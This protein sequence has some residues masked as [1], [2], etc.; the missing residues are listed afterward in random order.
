M[1]A[2][3]RSL[4]AL[5]GLV[6]TAGTPWAQAAQ[7]LLRSYQRNFVLGG[8]EVKLQIVQDAGK[9]GDRDLGPLYLQAVDFVLANHPLLE[10]EPRCRVLAVSALDLIRA[11]GFGAARS[12]AWDLFETDG[13]SEVRAA[14]LRCLGVI[15]KGD[16]EIVQ[17][18]NLWLQFQNAALQTG[19]APDEAVTA[20]AVQALAAL[21]EPSSFAVLF[22]TMNLGYG[23]EITGLAR[24]ALQSIPGDY[25][26]LFL[27]VMQNSPLPEKLAAL[28][29]ALEAGRLRESDKGRIAEFALDVGLHA[30]AVDDAS[31]A[32]VRE[33]RFLAARALSQRT[34]SR[35]TPLA[36]EHFDAV[37][38]EYERGL[39]D[40]QYL[41]ESVELLG[42]C[43]THEAAIRLTQYLILLNAY[44]ERV[45]QFDGEV[46]LAVIQALGKL[47]DKV[48][49]D[50][51]MYI[52]Y[53]G[54]ST[55]IKAAARKV[56]SS[57]RW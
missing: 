25:P 28:K 18:I 11:V 5:L 26:A 56:R 57:L 1:K 34:W 3:V 22:S 53:L 38:L 12:S 45:R 48:A 20:A 14:C 51:L 42:N 4:A 2:T 16:P 49:F 40:R 55:E 13:S 35:A 29:L 47:G 23:A 52:E 50:D 7:D 30:T 10:D 21:G 27:G 8:L 15:A 41:L 39:T 32:A 9:S 24:E 54:Y 43:G 37:L 36:I 46:V 19:Q 17:N 44:T 31:R 33:L 6:L